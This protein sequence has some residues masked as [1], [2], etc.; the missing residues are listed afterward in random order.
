MSVVVM[1]TFTNSGLLAVGLMIA[2]HFTFNVTFT[3]Y[4]FKY[5]FI[6][7]GLGF[8]LRLFQGVFILIFMGVLAH[9][10]FR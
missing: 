4:Q 7:S 6:K 3:Y 1:I 9:M 5:K 2:M 8:F 10:S